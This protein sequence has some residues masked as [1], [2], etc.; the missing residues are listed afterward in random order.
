[1]NTRRVTPSERV[2][3]SGIAQTL[4]EQ[5]RNLVRAAA[6]REQP[7][8]TPSGEVGQGLGDYDGYG[9]ERFE[10]RGGPVLA[11]PILAFYRLPLSQVESEEHTA[12]ERDAAPS[13][14]P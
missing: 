3:C 11:V 13:I 8:P 4:V 1:M 9:R 6:Y 2:E 10:Y 5:S 14:S 7:F 12:A